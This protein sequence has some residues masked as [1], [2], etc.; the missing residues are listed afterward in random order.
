[1]YTLVPSGLTSTDWGYS[2]TAIVSS[3]LALTTS[4]TE[5][6]SPEKF[7]TNAVLE[8]G[9]NATE[10]GFICTE[11]VE[12]IVAVSTLNTETELLHWLAT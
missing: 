7:A 9:L 2:P 4:M 5:T 1:M 6:L 8:S 3:V 11:M 12:A 10:K